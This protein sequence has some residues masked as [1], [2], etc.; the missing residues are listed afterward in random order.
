MEKIKSLLATFLGI[1]ESD[2]ADDDSLKEDL[3]MN[4]SDII[5]FVH[6]LKEN[7]LEIDES[8]LEETETVMELVDNI[9]PREKTI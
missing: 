5:D 9:T 6:V 8:K 2:I 4:P 7:G 3:H 1:E